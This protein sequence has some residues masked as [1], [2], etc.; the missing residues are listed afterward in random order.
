LLLS[1]I[2]YDSYGNPSQIVDGAGR[3]VAGGAGIGVSVRNGAVAAFA[4]GPS[5]GT[6]IGISCGSDRRP[7][8]Y[9]MPPMV[10][11][12]ASA[13]AMRTACRFEGVLRAPE[14]GP[15]THAVG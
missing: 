3:C 4:L 15:L 12:P 8:A 7:S 2:T 9:T 11:R 6:S 1:T 13:T 14:A 5:L 10:A